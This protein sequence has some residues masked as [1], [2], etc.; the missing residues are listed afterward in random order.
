MDTMIGV[1]ARRDRP[2]TERRLRE[3]VQRVLARDGIG[4]LGV[5]AVAAEAGCDKKLITR[6]FGGLGG[7]LA[8]CL[9][10]DF[11]PTIEE[12]CGGNIASIRAMPLP[13]RIALMLTNFAHALMKR[14]MTLEFLAWE[15]VERT[16]VTRVLEA[17]RERW[18]DELN[19]RLLDDFGQDSRKAAAAVAIL[20]AAINYLLVRRRKIRTF[21]GLDLRSEEGWNDV[22]E[23]IELMIGPFVRPPAVD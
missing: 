23:A 13:Q 7:L 16:E 6:Y 8:A 17:R 9:G 3:A 2:G 12:V 4:A 21:A 18:S 22:R 20:A 11:W 15:T 14:P 19:A 5:N 10:D 1:P